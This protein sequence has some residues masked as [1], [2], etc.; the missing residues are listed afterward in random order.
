MTAVAKQLVE[1]R[2]V[3][4]VRGEYSASELETIVRGLV[5]GGITALE[6]TTN[7]P[8]WQD[9]LGLVAE[10]FGEKLLLGA[11]T[12][13]T[14]EAAKA[15][16]AAGARYIIS[17]HLDRELVQWCRKNDLEPIPG[18]LTPTEM[19]QAL[20]AGAEILKLFPAA[21][22]GPDYLRLI[23]GP[24][25][26]AEF[27]VTGGI[28]ASNVRGFFDAGARLAGAGGKLVPKTVMSSDEITQAAK[29]L[30]TAVEGKAEPNTYGEP[31]PL[32]VEP[33][34]QMPSRADQRVHEGVP[35]TTV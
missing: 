16:A 8:G 29:E 15:A 7:S 23:R 17:P 20:Q 14:I 4:I 13:L 12:V 6:I 28:D 2:V 10:Q 9:H 3:A 34:S 21:Y 22:L 1:A 32:P 30:L 31:E 11:G 19:V 33:G 26:Q 27:M 35:D 5:S 25:N 24:L 18:V